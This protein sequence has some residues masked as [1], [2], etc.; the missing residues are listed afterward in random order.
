ML[1]ALESQYGLQQQGLQ[2]NNL[3]NLLNAGLGQQFDYSI[4]PAQDSLFKRGIK[5][6]LPL[7]FNGL[8]SLFSNKSFNNQPENNPSNYIQPR[9]NP[10]MQNYN[11][12]LTP[13]QSP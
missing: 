7:A 8:G 10:I 4:T 6:G 3:A 1:D 9:S 11:Q 2:S 13:Q 5:A 12:N